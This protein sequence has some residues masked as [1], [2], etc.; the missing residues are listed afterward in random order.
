MVRVWETAVMLSWVFGLW[1]CWRYTR[2]AFLLGVYLSTSL[3]FGY[4]FSFAG[5]DLWR[6]TFHPDSI[7]MFE[8]FGRRYALWAPLSYGFFFG[9]AAFIGLRYRDALDRRLGVWQYVLSFPLLY[10]L[11]LAIEGTAIQLWQVNVYH[12][13]PSYLFF[14]LPLMHF[15]TTGLMFTGTLWLSRNSFEILLR[16]GWSD[17]RAEPARERNGDA[18]FRRRV[19]LL[20]LATPQAAFYVALTVAYWLY[21]ALRIP[22][23][24][25]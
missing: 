13:P 15:V 5:H 2:R 16:A 17:F 18:G 3:T 10:A 24:R 25:Y 1:L 20:G 8:W 9:I 7:W 21:N 14:N 12:L 22:N 11:N 4:D 19:F 6:M 23:T